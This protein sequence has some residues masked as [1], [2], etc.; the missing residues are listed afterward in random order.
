MFYTRISNN[1]FSFPLSSIIIFFLLCPSL[2]AVYNISNISNIFGSAIFDNNFNKDFRFDNRFIST[3]EVTGFNSEL[4]WLLHSRYSSNSKN[5]LI[6]SILNIK[7]DKYNLMNL[8]LESNNKNLYMI[9][10]IDRINISFTGDTYQFTFGRS[11]ATWS[12]A[13][14]FH[15]TDF[16]NPQIS[17]FYDGSYKLG[18]DM[19]YSTISISNDDNFAVIISPQ[20]S[21]D[22][23]QLTLNDATLALKYLH[24]NQTSDF[25]II[26]AQYLRDYVLA[27]GFSTDFLFS[28]VLK[29]DIS[30]WRPEFERDHNYYT[31]F[32]SLEKSI[33][34]LDKSTTIFIEFYK[35]DFGIKD[36][37]I[38]FNTSNINSYVSNTMH[39]RL[40]HED[41]IILGTNYLSIGFSIDL[42]YYLKLTYSNVINTIDTSSYHNLG[43]NY[44]YSDSLDLGL[45]SSMGFGSKYDEFGTRCVSNGSDCSALPKIYLFYITYYLR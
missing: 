42:S 6:P 10:K 23:K 29:S 5:Y 41:T 20:R 22:E 12:R 21:I 37:F 19:I 45:S 33:D 44:I 28:S 13:R 17:G 14:M 43:I 34:I 1:F 39:K 8:S 32:L 9:N 18:S 15:V 27:L 26:G 25:S 31:W 30:I 3:Y 16:L 35:N 24:S 7:D 2:P 11:V 36:N 4:H 38:Y 40:S